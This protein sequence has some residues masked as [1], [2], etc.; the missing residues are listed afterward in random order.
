M[1]N[2]GIFLYYALFWVC[3]RI[4]FF[5]PTYLEA[6]VL[7]SV[8]L[9][10]IILALIGHRVFN[11]P[12]RYLKQKMFWVYLFLYEIL[13]FITFC[14]VQITSDYE[15]KSMM[16]LID[17]QSGMSRICSFM[18]VVEH[19][20]IPFFIAYV[21]YQ[22]YVKLSVF[23][24]SNSHE[25]NNDNVF[26][27]FRYPKNLIGLCLCVFS[28]FKASTIALY[29]SGFIYRFKRSKSQL[30][31]EHITRQDL[32]S[33]KYFLIDTKINLNGKRNEL[34]NLVGTSWSL[35]HNCLTKFQSIIGPL[36]NYL[37]DQR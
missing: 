9:H 5:A 26:L 16:W 14:Y 31:C 37:G 32:L 2:K 17:P 25:L 19:L 34:K 36:R 24:Y 23:D 4:Y 18:G 27:I 1:K 3:G 8:G 13:G 33:G 20:F 10:F 22:I 35:K 29:G 11:T 12:Y 7:H 15:Y 6:H 28:P 21:A 30:V